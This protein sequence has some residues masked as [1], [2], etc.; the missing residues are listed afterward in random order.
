MKRISC[1]ILATVIA[2]P[3][4]ASCNIVN[5][6]DY[7]DCAG[8]TINRGSDAFR[9]VSGNSSI[10]G[11]SDGARVVRGGRLS[12]SGIAQRV[13]VEDGA[14]AEI[15]GTANLVEVA[16]TAVISGSVAE[17]KLSGGEVN[18]S[19]VVGYV[20]GKGI[21]HARSGSVIEG[22]PTRAYESRTLK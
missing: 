13:I 1:I 5:G 15:K 22:V 7:G 18:I 8:V 3:A 4:S 10:S 20:S 9:E 12:V 6:E 17:I 2:A 19:G 16:G 14:H 11:I 21:I